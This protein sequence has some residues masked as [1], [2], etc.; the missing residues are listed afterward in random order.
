[1]LFTIIKLVIELVVSWYIFDV[2]LTKS[3]R[4]SPFTLESKNFGWFF[5]YILGWALLIV[6][7]MNI[8]KV[9]EYYSDMLFIALMNW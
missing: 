7:C 3:N 1:M 8:L 2:Y 4:M 6:A 5:I 9:L